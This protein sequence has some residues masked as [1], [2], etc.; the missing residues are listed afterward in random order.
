[1]GF[2]VLI[3][4]VA[5]MLVLPFLKERIFYRFISQV[6]H[7]PDFVT[8]QLVV[9]AKYEGADDYLVD[10]GTFRWI[11]PGSNFKLFTAAAALQYLH[12]DFSFS[13]FLFLRRDGWAEHLVL[14]GGGDPSFKQKDFSG[15]VE[16]VKKHGKISGD[17]FYDDSYFEGEQ[18]GPS[19]G[20]DWVNEYF[21]VPITGLQI[22]DNLLEIRGLENEKTKR[23]E[24]TTQPL[25]QYQP[26]IDEMTYF[27]D[28]EKL[29][30]PVTAF[31]D[32]NGRVI[33]KG[34]SLPSLP[35][36]AFAVIKDPSRSTAEVLKQEL[37]KANLISPAAKV[38]RFTGKK[39]GELLFQYQSAL[40]KDLVYRML[41]FSKNN[42]A[43][44]LVRTLGRQ[45][46]AQG[47]QAQGVEVLDDFLDEAGISESAI[48]AVDGSGLSP[49]TRVSADAI[50]KLFEYVNK[51]E[52]N[53]LFWNS[54]PQ[55]QVDGT[56]KNRFANAGLQHT[57]IAKTGTHE[58]SSSLSGKILREDEGRKNI[59]FSIHVYNHPFSTEESVTRVVPIID[60]IVALLDQQF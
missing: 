60:K 20:Q 37:V 3:G 51:Q 19:W 5:F 23:F 35:F 40:L 28:P 6:Q 27:D 4:T 49:Q 16:A 17:I 42:Y 8:T 21:A 56:L 59:L 32:N 2:G 54:L 7:R 18:L 1:M 15:F 22:N 26:I 24:L 39:P 55:S 38:K 43:E 53:D 50:V 58:F 36:S 48:H 47:T 25:E 52:W 31:L 33:L 11:H 57:V 46:Q 45:M 12:P 41:K 9:A 44:T 13:T 10:Y 14:R 34:D 30:R 29:K